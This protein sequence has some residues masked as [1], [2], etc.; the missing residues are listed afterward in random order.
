MD[1]L[2]H[3]GLDARV[4]GILESCPRG[5]PWLRRSVHRQSSSAIESMIASTTTPPFFGS[6]PS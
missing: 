2:D 5:F 3:L 4:K 1:I 6:P